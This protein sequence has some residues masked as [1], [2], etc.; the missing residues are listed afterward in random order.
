LR[1]HALLCE[2]REQTPVEI[3]H[4]REGVAPAQPAGVPAASTRIELDQN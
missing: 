2:Q 3:G 4:G 1:Q